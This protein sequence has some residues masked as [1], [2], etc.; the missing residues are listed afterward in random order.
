MISVLP[1][2]NQI[3]DVMKKGKCNPRKSTHSTQFPNQTR[4]VDKNEEDWKAF[5]Q[6][7]TKKFLNQ[8][9]IWKVKSIQNLK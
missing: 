5:C 4:N 6:M 7:Q 9:T 8:K 3:R 2:P 1:F